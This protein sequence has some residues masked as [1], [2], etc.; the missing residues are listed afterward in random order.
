MKSYVKIYGPPLYKA[1]KELEKIAINMPE[2]CMLSAPLA[3]HLK[4][5]FAKDISKYSGYEKGS[6]N[7]DPLLPEFAWRYFNSSGLIVTR[8][9]CAN[10]ISD[11]G[12][13]LEKYDFYFEWYTKPSP[14]QIQEL[15]KKID[16]ALKPLGCM[17][18][19]TTI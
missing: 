6:R 2:V 12:I 1:L 3:L 11:S 16:L 5:E 18:T 14:E 15:I 4:T 19:I 17:Y 8:E 7:L 9:R 13:D 10:V